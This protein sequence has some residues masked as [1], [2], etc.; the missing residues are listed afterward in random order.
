M[1]KKLFLEKNENKKIETK[2][3]E[4]KMKM[5]QNELKTIETNK[6]C[7]VCATFV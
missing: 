5:K 4:N 7:F 2:N 6:T 1:T 3:K